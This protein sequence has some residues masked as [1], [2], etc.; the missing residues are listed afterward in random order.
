[1]K[2][3]ISIFVLLFSIGLAAQDRVDIAGKITPPLGEDP[4]GISI[5]NRTAKSA[6]ISNEV[7][8]FT[9]RVAA[10][11]T[12]HFSALQYQDF[13]VV[14]DEGVVENRQLNVFI[15]EAVTELPEVVV[16]P[17]DLSGNV[18]VDVRVIPVAETDL[19]TEA[20]AEINSYEY[21][22]RPDSL[23]SPE[24]AAMREA[25][26]HSGANFANIFREIFRSRNVMTEV[27]RSENIDEDVKQ[28]YNDEFFKEY[29][30]I[31]P[32]NINEFIYF[33]EDN[34]LTPQMLEEENEL[35]LIDFLVEQSENYRERKAQD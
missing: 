6:A 31:E 32:E 17:Y 12:L 26:I 18:E 14:V 25:M 23:T 7:G 15:S 27:G 20:A 4:Q 28:L 11:D 5:V 24:N 33:A 22:F 30:N 8:N 10:G 9:I 21:T 34:G 13:S 35:E 29:L 2:S 19:P 3:L 16:T 1:M